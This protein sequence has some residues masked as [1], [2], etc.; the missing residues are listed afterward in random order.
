LEEKK[1]TVFFYPAWY[2]HRCDS[3][4]GLFVKRHAQAVSQFAEVG[5]VFVIGGYI[6]SSK[7]YDLE[8]ANEADVKTV[9]I[10]F[11][12]STRFGLSY[13][14][15]GARYIKAVKKGYEFLKDRMGEPDV[16]HVHVLTR[17]GLYPLWKKITSG[18]PYIVTEHWSRYLPINKGAYSG[19]VRKFLTKKVVKCAF[20]VTPVSQRLA[21]AMQQYGLKNNRYTLINNVVDTDR[22]LP[23]PKEQE[24]KHWVHVSCFDE[25]PKNITG[26]LSGFAKAYHQDPLLAL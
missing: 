25:H 10:Y 15:N 7:C 23:V 8:F 17:A 5:V 6:D 21:E 18:I 4:F 1:L 12:K 22:F 13:F 20:A 9:R 14:I 11:K 24:C 19:M 2:P 26:L 3:M 16:N